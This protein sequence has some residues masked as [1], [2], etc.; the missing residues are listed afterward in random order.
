MFGLIKYRYGIRKLNKAIAKIE[1]KYEKD[2]K[3]ATG[4]DYDSLM[5]MIASEVFPLYEE[6]EHLKTKRFCQ[7]SNK[8]EIPIPER[9]DENFW[10]KRQYDYGRVLTTEG[11]WEIKKLLKEEKRFRREG[12]AIWLTAII[13]TI[14]AAT[15]FIAIIKN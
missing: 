1:K 4:N 5:S 8:Y 15:G 13:G 2:K 6:I 7:L 10:N 9:E 14:G 11:I 12:I 3:E